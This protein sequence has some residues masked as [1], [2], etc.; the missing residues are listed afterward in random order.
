MQIIAYDVKRNKLKPGYSGGSVINHLPAKQE[1]LKMQV[2]TLDQEEPW[3]EEMPTPVF[4][5]GKSYGQRSLVSYSPWGCKRV[6]HDLAT[7][8]QK[9][10]QIIKPWDV[11]RCTNKKP[12]TVIT[13]YTPSLQ[14]LCGPSNLDSG[15]ITLHIKHII[16]DCTS[17]TTIK[18][19]DKNGRRNNTNK[20]GS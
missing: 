15:P 14:G 1:T 5:P 18:A 6:G 2:W 12:L 20:N 19:V 3:V 7:K 4:L 17:A 10:Q 13:K 16:L 9:Q 8:Q 11:V